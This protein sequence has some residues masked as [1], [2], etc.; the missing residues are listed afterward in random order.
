MIHILASFLG[1]LCLL[2]HLRH[3][4]WIGRRANG[5]CFAAT[6]RLSEPVEDHVLLYKLFFQLRVRVGVYELTS[7]CEVSTS[8]F[9]MAHSTMFWNKVSL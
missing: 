2:R 5:F 3:F 9:F 6:L 7:A 4:R 1:H 8:P